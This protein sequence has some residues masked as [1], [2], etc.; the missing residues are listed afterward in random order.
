MGGALNL[1]VRRENRSLCF[2]LKRFESQRNPLTGGTQMAS[3]VPSLSLSLSLCHYPLSLLLSLC[4]YPLSLGFA[5]NGC[6]SVS[7]F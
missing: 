5:S 4:R 1:N 2:Q 6:P 3:K 7:L